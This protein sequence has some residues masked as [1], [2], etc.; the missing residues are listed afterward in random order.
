MAASLNDQAILA[1]NTLFKNRVLQSLAATCIAVTTEAVTVS[2]L[3][4]HGRRSAF[5]HMVLNNQTAYI[6]PVAVTVATDVSVIGD[7]TQAGTVVLTAGNADAQQALVTDPHI[8]A[9][10]SGQFNSF[11][12]VES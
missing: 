7:A 9:A 1:A 3:L 5:A 2:T 8:S 11:F 4:I 10:L 12:N 6:V